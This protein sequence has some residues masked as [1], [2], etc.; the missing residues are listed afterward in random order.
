MKINMM[1]LR[2]QIEGTKLI[3]I[4]N[5]SVLYFFKFAPRM[6][7]IPQILISGLS[8]FC[9]G[10]CLRTVVENSSFFSFSNSKL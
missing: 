4:M 2:M 10:A 7:Q 3:F 1:D 9:G 8:K 6:P 5:F